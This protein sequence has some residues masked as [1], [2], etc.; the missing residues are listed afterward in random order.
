M[1]FL[2]V[3]AKLGRAFNRCRRLSFAAAIP[4]LILLLAP[5]S[6]IPAAA[7]GP[8]PYYFGQTTDATPVNLAMQDADGIV[9]L[10]IPKSYLSFSENWK[11]GLQT[12]V[13]LEVVAPKM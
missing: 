4:W 1:K 10:R 9:Q 2:A 5:W 13:N 7:D 11:G 3:G 6:I 8:R 12:V